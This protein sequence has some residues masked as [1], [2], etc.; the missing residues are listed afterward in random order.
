[1]TAEFDEFDPSSFIEIRQTPLESIGITEPA[2]WAV[3]TGIPAA[4]PRQAPIMTS[5]F[6]SADS[7]HDDRGTQRFTS[8]L[9]EWEGTRSLTIVYAPNHPEYQMSLDSHLDRVLPEH[10]VAELGG[11]VVTPVLVHRQE[12]LALHRRI[13]IMIGFAFSWHGWVTVVV[14]EAEHLE[15]T[16]LSLTYRWPQGEIAS[17]RPG[18]QV[19]HCQLA[20]AAVVRRTKT[21]WSSGVAF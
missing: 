18:L 12:T 15:D 13:G 6:S 1:M 2:G 19:R 3:L 20:H 9:T 4:L 10:D 5:A 16:Q 11:D 21:G 17:A 7:Y 8:L 14:L